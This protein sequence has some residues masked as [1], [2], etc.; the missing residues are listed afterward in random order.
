MLLK[1]PP[2]IPNFNPEHERRDAFESARLALMEALG[3]ASA[4]GVET[5]NALEWSNL[6]HDSPPET[7]RLVEVADGL[8]FDVHGVEMFRG[9]RWGATFRLVDADSAVGGA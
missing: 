7:E 8:G 6:F 1:T 2:M 9:G 3:V 4:D 5:V